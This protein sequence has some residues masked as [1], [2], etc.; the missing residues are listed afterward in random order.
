MIRGCMAALVVFLC[1]SPQGR[2]QDV[3]LKFGPAQFVQADGRDLVVPGY[4]VPSLVD[5]NNDRLDDLVVGEG[6]GGLPGKVRVYLNVGTAGAPRFAGYFYV[7]AN[8][9]DL[10]C[11]SDGCLGCY[12]RVADWDGDGRKDLIVG[13]AD[14]TVRLF[15]NIA[16]DRDPQFDVG[17]F[18]TASDQQTTHLDVGLRAAPAVVDWNDDGM[19]DLV[20][21]ALDGLIH[22]YYNCGCGGPVP[23][24]FYGSP[25]AGAPAQAN[26]RDLI[27]P[28]LR[29]SPV[30]V[31]LDGDELPDLLAGNTDGQILFYKNVGLR[32][33]PMFSGYSLVRSAG[34]PIHLAGSL[35]SRPFVCHWTG[36][37]TLA[38]RTG[39][40]DLLVGYGD[41]KVRLY[42][43]A[44]KEGDLDGDGSLGVNDAVL[45]CQALGQSD[46]E[47]ISRADLNHDGVIDDLDLQVFVELWLAERGVE[48]GI[49]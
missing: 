45:L 29:S 23:P 43:G 2:A 17:Q 38:S 18:I 33:L 26:G 42:R 22:V 37:S 30:I 8:G 7:Q 25:A 31:D 5:W 14:G 4:S 41:G 20:V 35:R 36:D 40:W 24:H 16:D 32:S 10:T 27:V 49:Q 3:S 34:Q 15:L 44:W 12:P 13:L 1:L 6:G 21:G 9:Q 46:A 39:P 48:E 47:S 19:M 11:P 28:G